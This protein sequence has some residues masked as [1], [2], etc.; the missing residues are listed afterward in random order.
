MISGNTTLLSSLNVSGTTT[1]NNITTCISSLNVSGTTNL[2][3]ATSCYG[4]PY[5]K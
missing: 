5:I 4:N 2:N 1:F 3:N